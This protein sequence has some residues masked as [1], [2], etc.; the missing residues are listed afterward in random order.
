MSTSNVNN[1]LFVEVT[2]VEEVS[3][4]G[5][6][7]FRRQLYRAQDVPVMPM[8]QSSQGYGRTGQ[9]GGGFYFD[10]QAYI[11]GIGAAYL[12]GNP[13]VTPAEIQYVWQMALR[14]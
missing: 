1:T 14:L 8:N 12:F 9:R 11:F 3:V 4:T 5:G 2:P 6:Y 10:L 7:G 13:G